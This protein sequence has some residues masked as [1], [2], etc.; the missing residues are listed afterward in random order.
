M[1]TPG[2]LRIVQ[3]WIAAPRSTGWSNDPPLTL[4]VSDSPSV[5]CQSRDPQSGQNAHLSVRPLAVPRDQNFVV[6]RVTRNSDRRTM[7]DMP[8]ADDDCA[9]AITEQIK[10]HHADH[11]RQSGKED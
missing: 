2:S 6:P 9:E 3:M 1:T 10:A 4:T 8:K 11:D 5:S 7:S